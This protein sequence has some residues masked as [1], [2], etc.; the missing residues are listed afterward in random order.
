M[1]REKR[2]CKAGYAKLENLKA[3]CD[4]MDVSLIE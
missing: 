4:V 3:A 2:K 1:M